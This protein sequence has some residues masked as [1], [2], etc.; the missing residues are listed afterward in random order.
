MDKEVE[1]VAEAMSSEEVSA[2]FDEKMSSISEPLNAIATGIESI[3]KENSEL[4]SKV[5]ELESNFNE[6][7]QSPSVEKEETQK[8]SRDEKVSRRQDYLNKLRKN[9]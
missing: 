3:L 5:S 8:F 7:K 6:F 9:S 1:E 2:I 4:K